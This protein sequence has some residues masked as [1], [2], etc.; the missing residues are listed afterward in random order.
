M[1]DKRTALKLGQIQ[2]L[3]LLYKYRFGSRQLLADSLGIKAGSSLHEKLNVLVKH[4]LIA[5]R[6]EKRLKLMGVPIAYYLTPKGLKTLQTLDKHDHITESVIK[7]SYR[8]KSVSQGFVSHTLDVYQYTN[9][10]KRQYPSLKIYLRRDMSRYSYFPNNP[11]D[12]FISLKNRDTTSRFFL[13]VIPDSLPRKALNDRITG[14]AEFFDEG[15][16][17]VTNNAPPSLLFITEKGTTE[18]RTR[19]TAR[20]ALN[21]AEMDDELEVYTT[22]FGALT[23]TDGNLNV[24]T[25]DDDPDE[26]LSLADI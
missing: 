19:R 26:L 25:G 9:A 16:W 18:T 10:L 21:R 6:I 14:Y 3:E 23:N 17:Q 12:A 22:T 8:D 4:G 7:G 5:K 24:W 15:G 13:D 1:A 2:I 20:F 11:P